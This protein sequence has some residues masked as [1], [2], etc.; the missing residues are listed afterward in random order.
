[1]ANI[2][3]AKPRLN[4]VF[5]PVKT[6]EGA[7]IQSANITDA[8]TTRVESHRASSLGRAL[9][10]IGLAATAVVTPMFFLGNA[11]G[12]DLVFH[13]SSWL[14]VAGQ[15]REGILFPRWAE[16][17]NWGYGEPRFIFYPPLSWLFGAALG[18]LL[19]WR[20][21]PGAFA[22]VAL[23]LAGASMWRFAREFLPSREAAAAGLI[24]AINPYFLVVVYDRSDFAE[25]L[26]GACFPLM[27]LGALQVV[28]TGWTGVPLLAAVFAAL[29][30]SNAPAAVIATYSLCLLLAV[31]CAFRRSIR[32]L[33]PGAAS[34]LL[35]FGLAAFYILP[36]AY[37]QR[38]VQISMVLGENLA[39]EK[40]FIFSHTGDP[41][42]ILFN[43]KI[44]GVALTMILITA[45]AAVAVGD[46]RRNFSDA[47]WMLLVVAA[48]STLLMFPPTAIFWRYLPKLRFVQFPWRWCVALGNAYAVFLAIALARP[49]RAWVAWLT[50]ILATS[51]LATAI[52]RDAWFDSMNYPV[53]SDGIQSEYGYEGTDEYAPLGFDRFAIPGANL[54]TDD[55]P[56]PPGPPV[57]RFQKFDSSAKRTVPASGVRVHIEQW[58]AEHRVFTADPPL[59]VMLAVRIADYPAWKLRVDGVDTPI[60]SRP[61]QGEILV[62]LG[63]G[64]HQVDLRFGST[65]DRMAGAMISGLSLLCLLVG[66]SW[67]RRT[68]ESV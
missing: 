26:A 46:R 55:Q 7:T 40:N 67:K 62:P 27:L 17:A 41:E 8:S 45:L 48:A 6:S 20:A 1:V 43:W 33:I 68:I 15:W 60:E 12:H 65:P 9:L 47:R 42:F 63:A 10:L 28:R 13:L 44:S 3:V 19:P 35:G 61:P 50:L 30:L 54:V 52:V 37:E 29:W 23:V 53:L 14:D 2:S 59:P 16:W 49:R 66:I 56:I 64:P 18:S 58:T 5:S 34:M 57:P 51:A 22:W 24:Y 39:P 4:P 31:A 21:A 36:A 38:W 32:P 11:S 25:L